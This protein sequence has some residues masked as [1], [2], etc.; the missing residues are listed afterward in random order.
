MLR[1][2]RWLDRIELFQILALGLDLERR[3]S[4]EP[5]GSVDGVALEHDRDLDRVDDVYLSSVVVDPLLR[6]SPGP[7]RAGLV[8]KEEELSQVFVQVLQLAVERMNDAQAVCFRCRW[9]GQELFRIVELGLDEKL[10]LWPRA[11]PG[12]VQVSHQ[13]VVVQ[14]FFQHLKP[15]EQPPRYGYLDLA[16]VERSLGGAVVRPGQLGLVVDNEHLLLDQDVLHLQVAALVALW[17][18]TVVV[19]PE[20]VV[21]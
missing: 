1:W 14:I 16:V 18:G 9:L 7:Q 21:A 8:L 15:Q 4:L 12:W 13:L 19:L 3:E 11:D 2:L 5:V 20:L 6:H 17:A 10:G